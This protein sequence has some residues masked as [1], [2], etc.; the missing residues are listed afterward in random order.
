[1]LRAVP[2][3]GSF[4]SVEALQQLVDSLQERS[5]A[6]G[7]EVAGMSERGA[8][9]H[10][11]RFG[12]GSLKVLLVGFPHA[13]EPIGGLTVFSLLTL[14]AQGNAELLKADVEWH[15]VPC[16]DPDG[17]ALNEAWSQRVFALESYL[18]GFHRQE[19]ADQAECSF[20]IRHK[21]LLFNE[22]TAEARILQEILQRVRPD[23]YYSLHNAWVGGAHFALTRG[24]ASDYYTQ[25]YELLAAHE[26]PLRRGAT[27]GEGQL[28]A[29][30]FEM[31]TVRGLYNRL[32]KT[33]PDPE[34][35]LR[36]GA[37]SWEY[38]SEIKPGALTFVTELPYV[39]HP[40]DRSLRD[41][42]ESYRRLKL[43]LDAD[44][45]Y[46]VTVILEEWDRVQAQ[47]VVD[48]PYHRKVFNGVISQ[49]DQLAEGLPAW[50]SRTRDILFSPDYAG[51]MTESERFEVWQSDRF[52]A[53][54]HC[55]EFVR[56]LRA[57]P[58][59]GPVER[60]TLRLESLFRE[61]LDE[62][63]RAIDF[64]RFELID[65]QSL[66]RVQLGSGLIVLNSL[67]Q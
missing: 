35:A 2:A 16:I 30:V 57:S 11:V 55:Y 29:G 42:G 6:F 7:I 26:I 13:N 34:R 10:H 32:E 21:K 27:P 31:A 48:S 17:A 28:A 56:L 40:S 15:V 33:L 37:C 61:A 53:L 65:L 64:S 3:F 45:K 41:T 25:L 58:Q 50:V 62:M 54:C 22:P 51:T 52:F 66:A 47:V 49:Q 67:L 63:D 44:N 46:L 4:C 19:L 1:M 20:P 24:L 59:T 12:E 43:R 9:I 23:L 18:R 8:P 5:S 38:L 60:A 36:C 14:L 39:R